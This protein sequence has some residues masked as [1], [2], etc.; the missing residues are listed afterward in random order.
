MRGAVWQ[1]V[2]YESWIEQAEDATILSVRGEL[3]VNSERQ[4][5]HQLE[6]LVDRKPFV[7]VDLSQVTYIDLATIRG[8]EHYSAMARKRGGRLVIA[9]PSRL[10]RRVF[11]VLELDRHLLIAGSR[12]DAL[13]LLRQSPGT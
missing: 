8:L 3:D 12:E 2:F 7:V 6:E 5:R 4:F 9:S 10:V 13:K 1:P 11:D